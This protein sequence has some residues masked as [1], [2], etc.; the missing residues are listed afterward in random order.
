MIGVERLARSGQA[1]RLARGDGWGPAERAGPQPESQR[2]LAWR[3]GL[4]LLAGKVGRASGT[5]ARARD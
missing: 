2:D 4:D 5:G 1:G 3:P